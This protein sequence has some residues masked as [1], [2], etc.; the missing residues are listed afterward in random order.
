MKYPPVVIVDETDAKIG[1]AMLSEVW[2]KG[3]YH[4]VIAAFITD[5][6]GRMLLQLRSPSVLYPNCWDQAVGGHVDEGYN[7]DQTAIKEMEE[8]L[9]IVNIPLTP[10][11]TY[12]TNSLDGERIMNQF[13]RVYHAEVPHDIRLVA[14]AAEVS[15]LRWFTPNELKALITHSQE[16]LT[17]GL[18]YNLQT[19]FP[20]FAA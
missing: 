11:A 2:Q 7:Y 16:H 9:G 15:E 1:S 6:L 14:E 5:D 10:I 12:R 19:Y 8:E 13:E 3:L 20:A 17:P 18:V 4:R